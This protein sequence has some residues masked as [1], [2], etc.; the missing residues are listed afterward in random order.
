[1]AQS[2]TAV[3]LFDDVIVPSNRDF[4]FNWKNDLPKKDAALTKEIFEA[5]YNQ[6]VGGKHFQI[7]GVLSDF[8]VA[9]EFINFSKK[10][11]WHCTEEDFE[12][13]GVEIGI[14]RELAVATQ[15][16]Y[17]GV[18]RSL[19]HYILSRPTFG[20]RIRIDYGVSIRQI[21]TDDNCIVHVQDRELKSE[22]PAFTH[23]QMTIVL[24]AL[25]AAIREAKRC[26]SKD[27]YPLM[28]D[29]AMFFLTYATGCRLSEV[30]GMDLTSFRP[31][32]EIPDMRNYGFVN[33]SRKGSK[34][35]GKKIQDVP[36]FDPSIPELMDWYIATVR[37]VFAIKADPNDQAIFFSERGK[38][39]SR[40]A[41]EYRFQHLMKIAG[42]EGRGFVPHC[43]RH[44]SVTHKGLELSNEANRI[45]H[46][47][48]F[49]ATTQGYNHFPDPY[50]GFEV[51]KL[52]DKMLDN[53]LKGG[54]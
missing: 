21:C 16:K 13:W 4:A 35:S 39:I 19:F 23:E 1:M 2:N 50:V 20:N 26:A 25:D 46:G 48:T 44:T 32:P 40:S 49:G 45:I 18:I 43:L 30:I 14:K 33:V 54:Q 10:P 3:I 7:K 52:H 37:P 28:R 11:I 41:F 17:Q 27:L 15:R 53:A 51:S 29:K 22:R 38:R 36:I 8:S 42:L 12:A 34:G 47:H 5:Y 24:D 6:K 9:Y 31:N